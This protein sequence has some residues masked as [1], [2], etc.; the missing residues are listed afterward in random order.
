MGCNKC[1]YCHKVEGDDTTDLLLCGQCKVTMYCDRKCQTLHWKKHKV[2]CHHH[3]KSLHSTNPDLS[4]TTSKRHKILDY[5]YT[6]QGLV[7]PGKSLPEG[8]PTNYH[9]KKEAEFCYMTGPPPKK[10]DDIKK[11]APTVD[12]HQRLG[13]LKYEKEY[14]AYYDDLVKHR[15]DWMTFLDH[16]RN[17]ITAR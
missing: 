2:D 10:D 14:K 13:H 4:T 5:E 1:D 8:V 6:A 3:M 12:P 17:F 16:P 9:L 11:D 7:E 15:E